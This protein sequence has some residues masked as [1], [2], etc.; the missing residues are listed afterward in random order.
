MQLS[1]SEIQINQSWPSVCLCRSG[2]E[3]ANFSPAGRDRH[4]GYDSCG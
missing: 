3:L 4:C 1:V 2:S